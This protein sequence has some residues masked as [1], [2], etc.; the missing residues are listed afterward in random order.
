MQINKR[1]NNKNKKQNPTISILDNQKKRKL[2]LKKGDADGDL[3]FSMVSRQWDP[4]I[5][6]G[7][8]IAADSYHG[9][10]KYGSLSRFLGF[11]LGINRGIF[12]GIR[13]V[14]IRLY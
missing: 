10:S 7:I 6:I 2:S 8:S 5:I 14:T 12:G 4:G 11:D 13:K 3:G 1:S 9:D